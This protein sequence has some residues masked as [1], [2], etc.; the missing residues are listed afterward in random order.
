[1]CL[2]LRAGPVFG[3][4]DLFAFGFGIILF[5]LLL[6]LIEAGVLVSL[7][8]GNFRRS[9]KAS[10][11]MNLT[12][13]LFGVGVVLVA[14]R[15]LTLVSIWVAVACAFFLCVLIEGGILMLLKRE[16]T[17]LNWVVSLVANLT[18][19]FLVILPLA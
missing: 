7:K 1:M 3:M 6:A 4:E 18:S 12:S 8:W 13:T 17:L 10:V 11:S 16:A 15:G 5:I 2:S 14:T 9:L 19:Y